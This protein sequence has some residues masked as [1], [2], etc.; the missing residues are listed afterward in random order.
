[1]TSNL[2]AIIFIH[3]WRIFIQGSFII[4]RFSFFSFFYYDARDEFLFCSCFHNQYSNFI[5]DI[6]LRCMRNDYFKQPVE[7][8]IVKKICI[9]GEAYPQDL[10][11][12]FWNNEDS[13]VY[14]SGQW[15]W[16]WEEQNI[17]SLIH[18]GLYPCMFYYGY[19]Y[20]YVRYS[21]STKN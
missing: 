18:I 6:F 9:P 4:N 8:S 10:T 3:F 17:V 15:S 5:E 13:K 2:I 20:T 21:D 16:Y 19:T 7:G 14:N 12:P 11:S 1:M